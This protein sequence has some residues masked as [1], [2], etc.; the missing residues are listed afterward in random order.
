MRSLYLILA[1]VITQFAFSQ[2]SDFQ[3]WSS[4]KL[5]YNF[6]DKSNINIKQSLR[7]FQNSTYWRLS[8][9]ELAYSYKINKQFKL[10][11]GY[12]YA[13]K[14]AIDFVY[15]KQ[16]FF[17][18]VIY[19]KKINKF[20]VKFR[21][22]MQIDIVNSSNHSIFYANREK[23]ELSRKINRIFSAYT[24]TEV[25]FTLPSKDIIPN[26]Y[27]FNKWRITGGVDIILSEAGS[28]KLF[29]RYQYG[30][31]SLMQNSYILGVT[32]KYEIN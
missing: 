9:T 20:S 24:S 15:N 25:Y 10:L 14:N 3:I 12:R 1:L 2:S 22:R 17:A 13:F 8:F 6:N 32:Y 4:L 7:T 31:Y 21:P 28:L 29:Y 18:D 11:A 30:K 16:R 27:G 19:T 5:K 26:L 23:L